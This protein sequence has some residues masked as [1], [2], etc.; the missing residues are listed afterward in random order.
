MRV[1]KYGHACLDITDGTS[2]LVVDPGELSQSFADFEN[3]NVLVI[4]HVHGDHFDPEKTKA[5]VGA[6]PDIKIFATSEVASELKGRVVTVPEPSKLYSSDSFNLEFFGELHEMVD[7]KTPQAQNFGVLVNDKLY[8]PG[9]SYTQCPK[10]F[11]VLAVPKSGPWF[12][13]SD[14]LPLI[15]N[16]SCDL[17]FSTHDGLLNEVGHGSIDA[18]LKKFANRNNKDYQVLKA[19]E[20]IEL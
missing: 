9:D 19:G 15:E 2:L 14:T 17:V 6:N 18:W 4:T 11:K 7:P 8:F 12:R 20:S 5:I 3:I 13:V 1:T 16:S 10:P